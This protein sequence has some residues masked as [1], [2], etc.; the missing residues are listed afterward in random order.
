[1][2]DENAAFTE[3]K[4]R[5]RAKLRFRRNHHVGAVSDLVHAISF[6]V[7]P[8][9]LRDLIKAATSVG[10]YAARGGEAPVD[11]LLQMAADGGAATALP[12]FVQRD[13]QMAFVRWMA[14]D[15]LNPGPWRVD[16][17]AG[18]G[19]YIVPDLLLCPLL[20]FDRGGGRIGQGGGHYD[21]YFAAHPLTLRIGI[22][23]SVQEVDAMPLE[24][25]D[26]PLDAVLTEQEWIVTGDRL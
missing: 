21:R 16:Q 8:T 12:Y 22:G 2:A 11:A 25:H 10:G 20:G 5:M 23:W 7:P 17:P 26:L 13:D 24:A 19:T 18:G 1:M 4:A 3:R 6:R 14:G 15:A 9:P